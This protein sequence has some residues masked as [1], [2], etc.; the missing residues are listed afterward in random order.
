MPERVAVALALLALV[1]GAV[2]TGRWWLARRDARI[3]RELRSGERVGGGSVSAGPRRGSRIVYFTTRSCVVCRLQQEPAL[4][5]LARELPGVR[6]ERH[7]AVEEQPIADIYG[8]LSVPTTAVYDESGELVTINRGFTPAA[9]LAAQLSGRA[10][11]LEGGAPMEGERLAERPGA[12]SRPAPSAR[13]PDSIRGSGREL[14]RGGRAQ[15]D[16]PRLAAV[17]EVDEAGAGARVTDGA[18]QRLHL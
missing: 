4:D 7:D 1:A 8:V 16:R 5:V 2:A 12:A 18:A 13:H 11:D 14:A 15:R 10:P 9:V 6:I 17:V 3:L